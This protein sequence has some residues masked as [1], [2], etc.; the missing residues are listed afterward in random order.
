V[1]CAIHAGVL[2]AWASDRDARAAAMRASG[3]RLRVTLAAG[4][5][6]VLGAASVIPLPLQLGEA[7]AD[8]R[9]ALHAID[10]A[11]DDEGRAW[12]GR[13]VARHRAPGVAWFRAGLAWQARNQ[14][15]DAE[16]SLREAHRLDPEVGDVAFA[17]AGVLLT[18]GKGAE[19]APLFEQAQ[20][21]GVRPDRVRLDLSLALRVLQMQHL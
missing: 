9:M 6:L 21:A 13:A 16:R 3:A 4:L 14:L 2:V 7:E 8:T 19:A 11:R 1:P 18:E 15:V 20:R 17:L 12:L 10:T 5:A